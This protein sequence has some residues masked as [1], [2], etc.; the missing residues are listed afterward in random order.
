MLENEMWSKNQKKIRKKRYKLILE[1]ATW[2][3]KAYK[4][5]RMNP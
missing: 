3:R 4:S 1:V 2:R 5:V